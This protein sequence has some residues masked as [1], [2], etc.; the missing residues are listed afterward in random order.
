MLAAILLVVA[1]AAD[2]GG[3]LPAR[4]GLLIVYAA[5]GAMGGGCAALVNRSPAGLRKIVERAL[6]GVAPA[7]AVG[8]FTHSQH[9]LITDQ[10]VWRA[11]CLS[12]VSGFIGPLAVFKAGAKLKSLGGDGETT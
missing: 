7:V 9:D 8:A 4:W 11:I 12:V 6:V 5:F 2:T 3:L 10:D 1:A